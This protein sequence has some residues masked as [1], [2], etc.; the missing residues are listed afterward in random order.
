MAQ[1]ERVG[2]I[3]KTIKRKIIMAQYIDKDAIVAEIER[4]E[5]ELILK[6]RQL[7]ML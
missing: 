1:T 4:I 3:G 2:R 5:N 7:K 6:L